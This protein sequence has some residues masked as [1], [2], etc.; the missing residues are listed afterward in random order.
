MPLQGHIIPSDYQHAS[1]YVD[2]FY[3]LLV[4]LTTEGQVPCSHDGK[5]SESLRIINVEMKSNT[6][7]FALMWSMQRVYLNDCADIYLEK[8]VTFKP[9]WIFLLSSFNF[10]LYLPYT[11]AHTHTILIYA[12]TQFFHILTSLKLESIL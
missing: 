2:G 6:Q 1:F 4:P 11:H 7:K 5:D 12:E 10:S 9:H 8:Y 3:S